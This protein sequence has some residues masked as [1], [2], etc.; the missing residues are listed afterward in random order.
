MRSQHFLIATALMGLA[1]ISNGVANAN[2][3]ADFYKG[4]RITM[5]IGYSSGG[6]YDRYARTLS[7]HM[8]RHIPGNPK[9]VAKNKTGAGSLILTNEVY[10]TLPQ[11]GTVVAAV[12]RGMAMEPLFGNK[13]AKFDP[14]KF[15]WLG[16]T[17]SEV[18]VCISMAGTGIKTFNDVK[19]RGMTVGGTGK[20]A[21][22]DAFP[23]VLNNLLDARFKLVTG[24]PGGNDINF[25]MEKGEVDGRCGWSWSS[26]K[27]TRAQW[28]KSGKINILIQMSIAKHAGIPSNVP[29]VMDLA[30]SEQ[31]KKIMGLIFARQAW[32]RP[33]NT[34]PN[35]PKARL[36]ALRAAFNATMTDSK[37]VADMKRQKL[38]LNPISGKQIHK[39]ISDLYKSPKKLVALAAAAANNDSALNI[40]KAQI[41]IIVHQGTITKLKRGGRRVQWKGPKAKGKLKV[42]GKTQIFVGGKKAK[43]KSLKVGMNCTFKVRGVES[44][45]KISCK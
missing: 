8:G 23:T 38:E 5:W 6:G 37:Y 25:A 4:K 40:S 33:F 26:V 13:Q 39:M 28:L 42:K 21:D 18:S 35:V 31:D 14:R 12:G 16:S 45:L 43:K 9:F 32:G 24:Y 17:N 30:K 27:A 41:P 29:L 15:G 7:R 22:T 2:E 19:T 44:A 10:S 1:T 34:T 20:G 3:V 11:D 36:Q